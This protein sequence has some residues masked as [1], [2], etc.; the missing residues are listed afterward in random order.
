MHSSFGI[1][2]T[3]FTDTS[4]SEAAIR[5]LG[6]ILEKIVTKNFI[7]KC[8]EVETFK[9]PLTEH[10]LHQRILKFSKFY[11][12]RFGLFEFQN[13]Y[14]RKQLLMPAFIRFSSTCLSEHHK[15]DA[16]F[17]KQPNYFVL[18]I[19]LFKESPKKHVSSYSLP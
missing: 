16:F 15:V 1:P 8:N 5:N 19:F 7:Y 9:L 10:E 12:I 2:W 4:R 13:T 14:L 6:K 11:T 3:P 18:G 17:I